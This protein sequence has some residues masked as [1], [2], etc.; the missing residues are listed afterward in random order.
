LVDKRFPVHL[1]TVKITLSVIALLQIIRHALWSV[2]AHGT[3]WDGI[4]QRKKCSMVVWF[5]SRKRQYD[6]LLHFHAALTAQRQTITT[7]SATAEIAR[8]EWNGHSRSLEV[9][10]RSWDITPSLHLSVP[11]ICS[12]WKWKK[13]AGNRWTCFGVKVPRTLDYPT[14]DLNP[15]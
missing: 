1:T 9:F 10:N 13:T 11:H 8:D 12:R 5:N 3:Y 2:L 15:R 7:S 6:V 14:I 4:S